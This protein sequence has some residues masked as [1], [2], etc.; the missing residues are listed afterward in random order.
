MQTGVVFRRAEMTD[1]D[2]LAEK[3]LIGEGYSGAGA[4]QALSEEERLAQRAKIRAFVSEPDEAGWLAVD[5][6]TGLRVG[7]ILARYRDP[8]LEADTQAN[9]WLFHYLDAAI[10]PEDGR[11]CEVFNLWVDPAFRRR[12]IATQLKLA[13]EEEARRRGIGMMYTHTETT[14]RHVVEL[15]LK[16]GYEVAWR[17]LMDGVERTSLIKWLIE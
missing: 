9:R 15:N 7:M 13:A 11:F 5:E 12:G 17:G 14:N 6:V 3:D 8:L 16:L 4:E 2:F 10:F 1:L